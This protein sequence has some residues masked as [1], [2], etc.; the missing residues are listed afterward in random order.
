[1]D[2][3]YTLTTKEKDGCPLDQKVVVNRRR[4][5]KKVLNL[6]AVAETVCGPK[7]AVR[8][9]TESKTGYGRDRLGV[10]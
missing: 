7:Y 9:K 8:T 4:G 5:G 1:M 6:A 10:S 3:K 2:L